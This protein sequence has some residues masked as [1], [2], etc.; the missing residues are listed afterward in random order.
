VSRLNPKILPRT[1]E[2]LLAVT[3]KYLP[4][5]SSRTKLDVTPEFESAIGVPESCVS[6][7]LAAIEKIHR[8]EEFPLTTYI[9]CPRGSMASAFTPASTVVRPG[10]GVKAPFVAFIENPE[11]SPEKPFAT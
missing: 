5:G 10:R 11:I 6:A 1:E 3:Y 7:P 4:D 8:L 9:N 2:E